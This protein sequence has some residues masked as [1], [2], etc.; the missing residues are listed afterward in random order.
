MKHSNDRRPAILIVGRVAALREHLR[1][2]DSRPLFGKRILITRPR[3]QSAEFVRLLD[4]LGAQ[5]I[6]A[7]MISI[8]P[9]ADWGPLDEVVRRVEGF[10]WI[11][12]S[13]AHGADAFLSRLLVSPLDVRALKG[14]K[15]CVVGPATGERLT[16]IGLKVD[17]IPHESRPK[18]SCRRWTMVRCRERACCCHAPTSAAGHRRELRKRGAVVTEVV[19]YRTVAVDHERPG[20]PDVYRML[21]DRSSTSSPSQSVG[22]AQFRR[23]ARREPAIDLLAPTLVAS[24]EPVTAE[25]ARSTHPFIIVPSVLIRR[26]SRP[27]AHYEGRVNPTSHV[28]ENFET[29]ARLRERDASGAGARDPLSP[30]CSCCR[31]SSAK[32]AACGAR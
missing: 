10:D 5:P 24:I 22:G 27:S 7:P 31:C 1:W 25:A 2:F 4:G 20:G 29:P 15:F 12:F 3:E 6:E 13:S 26:W 30:A 28:A 9:P 23:T 11:V 16:R 32:D 19:A 8:A 17:L 18:P 14:V 21:L